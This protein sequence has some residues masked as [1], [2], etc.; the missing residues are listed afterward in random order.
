LD[1]IGSDLIRER[2]TALFREAHLSV[3][4]DDLARMVAVVEENQVSAARVRDLNDRYDEPAFGLPDRRRIP[5][6]P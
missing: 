1:D 6:S 3:S 4:D 2:L 5:G